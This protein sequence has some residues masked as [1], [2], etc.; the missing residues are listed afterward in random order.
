MPP[1]P[2]YGPVRPLRIG[3]PTTRWPASWAASSA[4]CPA[5]QN[6]AVILD[7]CDARRGG[8]EDPSG[9][10]RWH[11]GRL[12]E[13]EQLHDGQPSRTTC[14]VCGV[15]AVGDDH[16]APGAAVAQRVEAG[17]EV[18]KAVDRRDHDRELRITPRLDSTSRCPVRL[19]ARPHDVEVEDQRQCHEGMQTVPPP[20]ATPRASHET[21]SRTGR[22][23]QRVPAAMLRAEPKC[24]PR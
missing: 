6:H 15:R 8:R 9:A 12:V 16:L 2:G 14:R 17:T 10:Q 23:A 7:H 1:S 11:R 18:R 21:S 24:A 13:C 20:C 19:R 5:I 3:P 22:A 4:V